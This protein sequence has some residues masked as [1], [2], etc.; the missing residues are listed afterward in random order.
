MKRWE[1]RAATA[2]L[3][4]TVASNVPRQGRKHAPRPGGPARSITTTCA[5]LRRGFVS[6]GHGAR[7]VLRV[8]KTHSPGTIRG[9]TDPG[10]GTASL[11]VRTSYVRTGSAVKCRRRR[12]CA[13]RTYSAGLSVSAPHP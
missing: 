13:S 2:H 3:F 1:P 8:A 9:E 11:A 4:D 10:A 6:L 5:A 7:I 12:I